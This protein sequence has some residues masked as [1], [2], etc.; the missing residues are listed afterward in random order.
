M[1][2]NCST[3][4][5]KQLARLSE[6][7]RQLEVIATKINR[8]WPSEMTGKNFGELLYE[9]A[10]TGVWA[11]VKKVI[12]KRLATRLGWSTNMA[13][14]L[15][16]IMTSSS[17]ITEEEEQRMLRNDRRFKIKT[18]S[19][20]I[21]REMQRITGGIGLL[22]LGCTLNNIPQKPAGPAIRPL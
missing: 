10:A 12:I 16:E 19:A 1:S 22:D 14:V 2:N 21:I 6:L 13:K 17:S 4:T 11:D 3:L 15:L 18:Q 8:G 9:R 20:P 7:M 5:K